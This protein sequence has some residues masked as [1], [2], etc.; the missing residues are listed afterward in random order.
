MKKISTEKKLLADT[1]L[2]YYSEF[3]SKSLSFFAQ[4]LIKMTRDLLKTV[5]VDDKGIRDL[6]K[7]TIIE[8]IQRGR[9]ICGQEICEGNEAY[10]HLMAEF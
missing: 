1:I 10:Q 7:P 6:T 2:Q 3:S 4:P 8:L 9:C 5:K